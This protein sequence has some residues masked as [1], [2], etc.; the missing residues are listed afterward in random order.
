MTSINHHVVLIGLAYALSSTAWAIS[1]ADCSA[2]HARLFALYEQSDPHIVA[3]YE[4]FRQH[5]YSDLSG[6]NTR[7]DGLELK[8][9]LINQRKFLAS[10]TDPLDIAFRQ[11]NLC[12]SEL[13]V[14]QLVQN[15]PASSKIRTK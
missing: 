11:L 13:S 3:Q 10:A 4:S 5:R 8:E 6:E 12:L 2:E 15:T 14:R 1:S 7:S 9:A